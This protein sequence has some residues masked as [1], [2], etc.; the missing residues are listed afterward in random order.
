MSS[1]NR[2]SALAAV[3]VVAVAVAAVLVPRTGDVRAFSTFISAEVPAGIGS[4]AEPVTRTVL[5]C[6]DPAARSG[7]TTAVRVGLAPSEERLGAGSVGRAAL[8]GDSRAVEL[9]RGELADLSPDGGPTVTGTGGSAAGMFGF[10][11]DR[12]STQALA[13][14]SCVSPR[15]QWWFTGAGGGL[16][17]SSSLLLANVD[18]G[19]AVVDLR[20]LGP[21][22][23]VETVGTTGISLAPESQKRIDLADIAPQTD[24]IALQVRASRG[25]VAASV[26]DSLRSSASAQPGQEWLVGTDRPG[27]TLTLG[28]LPAGAGSPTLLVAN[29]SDLE[30]VVEVRVAGR[31]GTF[32]PSGLE[33]VTVPPGGLEKVDLARLLP[34]GEPV[35][36]VLRSR[37]P[38]VA[39]VR[40]GGAAD[41]AY[42]SAEATLA[43]LAAAPVVSGADASVQLTAGRASATADVAAFDDTGRLVGGTTLGVPATAT[44]SWSPPRAAA[45]VTVSPL[46]GSVAGAVVY[47]GAGLAGLA[48]TPLPNR[49]DRPPVRP[50]VR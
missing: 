28:G 20:V 33:P 12:R 50:A 39:S 43:G 17:H 21:E 31:S 8:G 37:V 34:V 29:P 3:A 26:I 49:V 27:R 24:D 30:A 7:V 15:S 42:A 32:T 10:R 19:P 36:L 22:G 45:Y 48:L 14:A 18:P 1:S 13:V 9:S 47:S 16:D 25:R 38:V 5:R 41:H 44:R 6:P 46:R 40:Y 11:T 23:E 35:S 2:R 4:S